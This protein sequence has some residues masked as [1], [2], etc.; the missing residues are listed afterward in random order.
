MWLAG[1]VVVT[2]HL[3]DQILQNPNFGGAWIGFVKLTRKILQPAYYQ[4][5]CIDYNQTLHNTKDHQVLIAGWSKFAPNKS[6]MA[7]RTAAIL[8]ES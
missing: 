4:N 5:Y 8:E 3:G 2:P 7:D 6:K 1:P